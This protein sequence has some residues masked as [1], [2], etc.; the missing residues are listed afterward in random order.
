MR[1]SLGMP[2]LSL[3]WIDGLGGRRILLYGF[4]FLLLFGIF[5]IHNF[6]HDVVVKRAI[7]EL[8]RGS[9][10]PGVA[11][12]RFA[13]FRGYELSGVTLSLRSSAPDDPPI[14]ESSSLY[15]RPGLDG[16]LRGKLSSIA[17]QGAFYGGEVD[18]NWSMADGTNRATIQLHDLQI[19][20]YPYV[21]A[22][23]DEG[24]LS[25]RLS[26][27]ASI[28]GRGG[29]E[30]ARAAGELS[31]REGGLTGVKINGLG[32]PDLTFGEIS[33]KFVRQGTRL[34]IQEF[35][36]DGD[37]IKASGEGQIV[38]REP[39][40]DSVLNLRVTVMPGAQASEEVKTLLSLVPRP[41]NAR[42]DAPLTVTG[43]LRQPRLR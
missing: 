28:E 41:K 30:N 39:P 33:F 20:R 9:L 29:I 8:N 31:I 2:R 23:F 38:L 16:L 25:G 13:W 6:P 32:I 5:F 37:Q 3:D 40:L 12:A 34:D 14:L 10:L 43:T 18:G 24:S 22:L 36:A 1:L 19:G 4:Y 17:V 26:G 21:R 15:V 35:R 27:L 7:R 42:L 11:R